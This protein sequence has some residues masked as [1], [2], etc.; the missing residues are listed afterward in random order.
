VRV[1]EIDRLPDPLAWHDAMMLNQFGRF[2][3]AEMDA[4]DHVTLEILKRLRGI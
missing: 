1:N 2:S 3:P 4:A